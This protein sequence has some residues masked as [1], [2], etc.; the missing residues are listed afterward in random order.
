MVVMTQQRECT[1][2]YRTAQ[3]K[4]VKVVNCYMYFITV[5]NNK[6]KNSV[7]EIQIRM[8]KAREGGFQKPLITESTKDCRVLA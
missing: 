2:C 8:G 7:K 3:L 6:T 5:K 1:Y 4:L